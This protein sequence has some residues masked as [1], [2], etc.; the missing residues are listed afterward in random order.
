MQLTGN[1]GCHV[2]QVAQQAKQLKKHQPF[3]DF[4]HIRALTPIQ[5][6][7]EK[8]H[9]QCKRAA[10]T[11]AYNG[12]DGGDDLHAKPGFTGMQPTCSAVT[13][14]ARGVVVMAV[15]PARSRAGSG[16]SMGVLDSILQAGWVQIV[17]A[18]ECNH[19]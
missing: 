18:F 8:L 16:F 13:S 14:I 2:L 6:H 5:Q 3:Q 15:R 7:C 9:F 11:L 19:Q 4:P 1:L 12:G 17:L 10:C